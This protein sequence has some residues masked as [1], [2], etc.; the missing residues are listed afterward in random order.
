MIRLGT[1]LTL[2]LAGAVGIGLFYA[3]HRVQALEAELTALQQQIV[4]D[5]E[6]IHVLKAEW[7]FLND[8]DRLAELSRRY[9][10]LVPMRGRQLATLADVPEKLTLPL[11]ELPPGRHEDAPAPDPAPQIAS[12]SPAIPAPVVAAPVLP[13]PVPAKAVAQPPAPTAAPTNPAAAPAA[14]PASAPESP[15]AD[16]PADV[17]AVLASMRRTP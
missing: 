3:K 13:A 16:L 12:A 4:D 17:Q 14:G 15:F 10:D 8:P 11:P 5:R 7:S 6:A 1:V 9:L 2:G